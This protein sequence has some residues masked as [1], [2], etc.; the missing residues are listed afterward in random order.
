MMSSLSPASHRSRQGKR[1]QHNTSLGYKSVYT[2]DNY[3]IITLGKPKFHGLS[4]QVNDPVSKPYKNV[5]PKTVSFD[6]Y[7]S[8]LPINRE[9]LKCETP[10]PRR[11]I[12]R[13]YLP[14]F[15]SGV[16]RMANLKIAKQ[17]SRQAA[18]V[19]IP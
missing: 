16:D 15:K 5:I 1:K 2:N 11:F 13:N 12:A 7:S 3:H 18:A 6:Q 8:R 10:N 19:G 14:E 9:Q 17:L 4:I